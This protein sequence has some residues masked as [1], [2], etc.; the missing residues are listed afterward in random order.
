MQRFQVPLMDC[1]AAPSGW[2]LQRLGNEAA[3]IWRLEI[4]KAT[5][6]KIVVPA[7]IPMIASSPNANRPY[8]FLRTMAAPVAG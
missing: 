4:S 7:S 3:E 1:V 8:S 6:L 2:A 5:D